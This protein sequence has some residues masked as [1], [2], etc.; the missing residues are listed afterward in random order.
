MYIVLMMALKMV[1]TIVVIIARH[2]PW[3]NL[4]CFGVWKL[5]WDKISRR[6]TKQNEQ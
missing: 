3:V 2:V 1:V 6:Y 5:H 4:L